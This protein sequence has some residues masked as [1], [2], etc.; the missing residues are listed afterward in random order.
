[1]CH[2]I[3]CEHQGMYVDYA[4]A[5]SKINE[6]DIN[7]TKRKRVLRNVQI[8]YCLMDVKMVSIKSFYVP[9]KTKIV[10]PFVATST[11]SSTF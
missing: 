6:V 7:V 9:L 5:D 2:T 8:S 1:L 10:I 4:H 11:A 3:M